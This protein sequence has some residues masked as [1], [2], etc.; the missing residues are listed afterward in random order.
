MLFRSCALLPCPSA[1][2]GVMSFVLQKAGRQRPRPIRPKASCGPWHGAGSGWYDQPWLPYG[3]GNRGGASGPGSTV[4][5]YASS[6]FSITCATTGI[7]AGF[8][9]NPSVALIRSPS[10]THALRASQFDMR[11]LSA[12][13]HAYLPSMSWRSRVNVSTG[14]I[15]VPKQSPLIKAA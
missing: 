11:E 12:T 5:K 8:A 1:I 14:A 3:R 13:F 4:E 7:R 15:L 2:G 10:F 9:A 6:R